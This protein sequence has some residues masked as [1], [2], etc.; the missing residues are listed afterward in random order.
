MF[1]LPRR[2]LV[3]GAL[4]L[5]AAASAHAQPAWPSA[6]PV[7]LIV[8]FTA[9]G[10]TDGIARLFAQKLSQQIGQSV[11][12]DNVGGGGGTIGTQKAAQAAPDGYTILMAVDSPAAIAQYVNPQAVKYDTQRD[13]APVG[14][15]STLPLVIM[16]RPGLPASS[17][18]DVIALA[19][20]SPGKLTYA[21]SGI[22]TVLHLAMER[23]QQQ[24]GFSL[25]HVPYRGGAQ[26]ITDLIG[27]Q[28]DLAILPTGSAV[29]LVSS[30]KVKGLAV[31]DAHRL[32]ALPEVPSITELPGFKDLAMTAWIGIFAPAGT[33]APVI[34]R[35]N[36][37]MNKVLQMPDVRAKFDE[38]AIIAGGGS[39]ADFGAFV[40]SEQS[41]YERIVRTANIHE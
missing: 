38:Q 12:V 19:K 41:R 35:L 11:V 7:T 21:T 2:S 37:E 24:A 20:A 4:G 33:P 8:P 22:G 26:A 15:L 1:H 10:G 23:Y 34:E 14:M 36:A 32:A 5:V 13:F 31:T 6:K 17:F 25:V 30:K 16:G 3:L 27:N 40:K 28:V 39:A 9:G 18:Q 29:P